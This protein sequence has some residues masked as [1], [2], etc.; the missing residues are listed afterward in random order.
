MSCGEAVPVVSV[1]SAPVNDV[2]LQNQRIQDIASEVLRLRLVHS[3]YK[4]LEGQ[5]K[6]AVDKLQQTSDKVFQF[7]QYLE[8]GLRPGGSIGTL[9]GSFS[10]VE[11]ENLLGLMEC[12]CVVCNAPVVSK[13]QE[14][15]L[16]A[17]KWL[18]QDADALMRRLSELPAAPSMQ[19]RR[20]APYLLSCDSSWRGQLNEAGQCYEALRS[21]LSCYYQFSLVSSPM[22]AN[23]AQLQRQEQL[24]SELSKD[25]GGEPGSLSAPTKPFAFRPCSL[26]RSSSVQSTSSA[27]SRRSQSPADRV[28]RMANGIKVGGAVSVA[29]RASREIRE[30]SIKS[31]LGR[32]SDRSRAVGQ[33]PATASQAI[34]SRT[35]PSALTEK[36]QVSSLSG[37]NE[38]SPRVTRLSSQ[39]AMSTVLG[40]ARVSRSG[41][42]A[43]PPGPPMG[44]PRRQPYSARA[45]YTEA[46]TTTMQSV[47]TRRHIVPPRVRRP[48]ETSGGPVVTATS[49]RLTPAS[50]VKAQEKTLES[51]AKNESAPL[52]PRNGHG[53]QTA[54]VRSR[55]LQSIT[56]PEVG[57]TPSRVTRPTEAS[58]RRSQITP[59]GGRLSSS[60]SQPSRPHVVTS[61]WM[62]SRLSGA[63][64]TPTTQGVRLHARTT[65]STMPSKVES[66]GPVVRDVT[67]SAWA[68]ATSRSSPSLE[69]RMVLGR[70]VRETAMA[71]PRPLFSARTMR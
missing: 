1:V 50:V 30:A 27:G 28:A 17:T 47:P 46:K 56:E 44:S 41:S 34:S 19:S 61:V 31:P 48:S 52:S 57:A 39:L 67:P 18:L 6:T 29:R 25:D 58:A 3:Q 40:M 65:K 37:G 63:G 8:Q 69:T 53:Q 32:L 62:S 60:A 36:R 20:L 35:K 12:L 5:L 16:A 55:S 26:K 54:F 23:A 14:D 15:L 68:L 9:G 49:S 43:A 2:D 59:I 71:T 70:Q 66:T 51:E 11:V 24:L 64:T 33:P 13:K 4:Q 22:E 10:G 42:A 45:S 21:W 7:S 38:P